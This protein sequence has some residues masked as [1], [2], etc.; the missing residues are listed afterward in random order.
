MSF[1]EDTFTVDALTNLDDHP[2][3]VGTSWTALWQ[4]TAGQGFEIT[5]AN[6]NCRQQNRASKGTIHTADATYPSA[7]YELVVSDL[8]LNRGAAVDDPLYLLV[9]IQDEENMYAVRLIDNTDTGNECQLYKKVAGTWT[10]LGSAFAPPADGSLCKLEIIGSA[11][12]F[13][14]DGVEVASATDTAITAAGKAGLGGGGGTELVVSTDDLN[15]AN[16]VDTLSINDLATGGVTVTPTT[17]A[18]TLTTFAPTVLTPRLVTPGVVALALT[19]FAPTVGIGVV[20]TPTT[21]VLTLTS[22]NPTVQTPV[23]VTLGVLALT[24]TTFAPTVTA[25]GNVV[26]T[27]TT[28]A[29]TLTTFAPTVTVSGDVVVTPTTLALTLTTFAPTVLT[30]RLVTPGVL[31]LTLTMFAP[32]VQIGII[33]TPGT[34]ALVLTLFAPTVLTPRLLTPGTLTLILTTFAPTL[35]NLS[36]TEASVQARKTH[37]PRGHHGHLLESSGLLRG[38]RI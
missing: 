38:R 24:L 26:V 30:P 5:A 21:A 10:A 17:A 7:D 6:D 18:L 4:T 34:L 15:N 31:S 20:V 36:I 19:T 2:P 13:Y 25:G 23:V 1:F 35:D 9:R 37:P 8:H 3:D 16:Y 12:K 27:P 11:L 28:L 29:L 33:V 32:T 22:F 14:D